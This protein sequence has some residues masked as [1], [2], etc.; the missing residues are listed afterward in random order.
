[1][2]IKMS[3]CPSGFWAVFVWDDARKEWYFVWSGSR[4]KSDAEKVVSEL[5]RCKK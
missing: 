5:R 2:N 1:M 4:N 3:L